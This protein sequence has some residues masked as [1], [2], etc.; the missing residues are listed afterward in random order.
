M[1]DFDPNRD[2]NATP[3]GWCDPKDGITAI[4]GKVPAEA[5]YE[6][7]KGRVGEGRAVEFKAFMDMYRKLPNPD[8]VLMTPDTHQ[9]PTEGSVLYALSGAL[10][11]RATDN[12]MDRVMTFAKR[13][14]PEFT[15][16]LIRD[17]FERDKS[18][19]SNQ[20]FVQWV[21]E[22]GADLLQ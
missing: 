9:V 16:L 12:N 13:L 7:F 10:A 22:T 20:S 4:I 15:T 17:A 11:Q 19:A 2:K 18:L 1:H 21:I 14:P 3:R 8:V 6:V 5:E